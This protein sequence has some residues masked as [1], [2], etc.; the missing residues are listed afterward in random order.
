MGYGFYLI[1]S[2]KPSWHYNSNKTYLF[3]K[4]PF[5]QNVSFIYRDLEND[6]HKC[7]YKQCKCILTLTLLILKTLTVVHKCNR[8]VASTNCS[9]IL[10]GERLGIGQRYYIT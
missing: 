8:V 6:C 4:I 9:R 3:L 10:Y 1:L 2:L 5:I 7:K